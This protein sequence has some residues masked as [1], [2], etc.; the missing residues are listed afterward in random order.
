MKTFKEYTNEA[1]Q[2]GADDIPKLQK[3]YN[4]YKF[5][6]DMGNKVKADKALVFVKKYWK[7]L[8]KK[9][10]NVT[11]AA[12]KKWSEVL[13]GIQ[14]KTFKEFLTESE[15]KEI[16]GLGLSLSKI[17]M[18]DNCPYRYYLQY[19]KKEKIDKNDYN[20]KFFKYGQFAHKYIESKI[21]GVEC[22]FNSSTLTD[23]D[24][25]KAT[26]NCQNVF[27]NKYI[28]DMIAKGGEAEAGFSMYIDPSQSDG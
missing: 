4:D 14:V 9:D 7:R 16:K 26:D 12:G 1:A 8:Q 23:E 19:F 27:N 17:K 13:K 18:F 28:S 5:N 25:Q 11:N 22:K 2:V 6:S 15:A 10:M 24:K 21:K 3:Y 20:P